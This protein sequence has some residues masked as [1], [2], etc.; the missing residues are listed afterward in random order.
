MYVTLFGKGRLLRGNYVKDHEMRSSWII[1]VGPKSNDKCSYMRHVGKRH[2]KKR[3][4]H[5]GTETKI[6][7]I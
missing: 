2:R 5:V 1:H 6:R 4:R 3:R 7:V